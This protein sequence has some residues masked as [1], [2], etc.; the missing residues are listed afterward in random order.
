MTDKNFEIEPEVSQAKRQLL[1]NKSN[2]K[3][4][5]KAYRIKWTKIF[6]KFCFLIGILVLLGGGLYVYKTLQQVPNVTEKALRS[7]SSSNMYAA[8]GTLIW[9]SA[10]YK[11]KYVEFEDIPEEYINLL[12][13]TEDTE[14]Y[15]HK[16]FSPKGLMNAGVSL[17]LSK[18]GKGEVRGGSGIDQQLIKLSVFSTSE[19]DR[20]VDR[21]VKELFLAM[22]LNH[23]YSKDQILEYYVNKIYLGESAYGIQT[24]ANVYYNKNLNELNLSQL[25][26]IAGLGQA[27]SQYNLYDNPQLVEKRRNQVLERA[28][29]VGSISKKDYEQ[30]KAT[31]I[32]DGLIPRGSLE[33]EIEQITAQ[34]NGFIQSALNQIV[35]LG[36]K[37]EKTPLQIKTTL[38]IPMENKVKNI[39]DNRP[40]L[41]QDQEQQAAVTI[42]DP[43]TGAVLTEVGGRFNDGLS[44]YNRASSS[45]RSSGSAI[46]PILDYGPAIEYLNWGT[47]YTVDGS[48]YTYKGT[49]I[50]AYDYGKTSSGP[51]TIRDALRLSKNTVAIR[52]LNSVGPT[53]AEQFISNLGIQSDQALEESVALGLN[54]SPTEL[55][56]AMGAFGQKGIYHPTKYITEIKFSDESVKKIE[57]PETKAMRESTA[58]LI[59]DILKGVPSP[60]G[61]MPNGE[62]PNVTYAAKTGTVAYPDEF[63]FSSDSAMDIWTT[64]YT[65]TLSLAVW[66]GYDTPMELGHQLHESNGIVSGGNL[67]KTILE[68][69][70]QGRDNSDWEKPDTVIQTNTEN[71]LNAFYEATDTTTLVTVPA[72]EKPVINSLETYNDVTI[73]LNKN[74][75]PVM[76]VTPVMPKNYKLNEWKK[77]LES[78]KEK[79]YEE[80]KNDKEEAAKV[81]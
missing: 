15:K 12:L 19:K 75:V 28:L 56:S 49:N 34:H 38:D 24:I 29:E 61:T 44:N 8:D 27:P 5:K 21:K 62:I 77:T 54:I 47:G 42:V 58:W 1:R 76:P 25:A 72:L 16:G 13:A 41:F 22:Q 67:F 31:P 80:H 69:V 48:P 4:V 32:D 39:L 73:D 3:K 70:S 79:F 81:E 40:E 65:K 60:K 35:E 74:F 50:T 17:V 18:L 46:K 68:E 6:F 33:K 45:N 36:Y 23:N 66:Q 55:A 57:L 51:T 59:T 9:T 71:G 37:I 20:T 11:R 52:T 64:G 63:G 2:P 26:I 14:F 78:E 43:Q 53:N 10:E 7:D 30:A